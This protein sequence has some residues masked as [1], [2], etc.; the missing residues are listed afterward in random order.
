MSITLQRNMTST[1]IVMYGLYLYFLGSNLR[2]TS[3]ALS[4]FAGDKRSYM[5]VLNGIE[6]FGPILFI[7]EKEYLRYYR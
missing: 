7:E 2:N 3:K 5:S 4:I 1:A 6:L